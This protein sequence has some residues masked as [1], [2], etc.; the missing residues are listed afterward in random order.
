VDFCVD[1]TVRFEGLPQGKGVGQPS[2]PL[3]Y[4]FVGSH[5]RKLHTEADRQGVCEQLGLTRMR[6]GMGSGWLV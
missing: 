5:L 6:K 3:T 1:G 4:R 2:V